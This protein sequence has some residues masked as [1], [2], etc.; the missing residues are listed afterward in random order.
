MDGISRICLGGLQS[1]FWDLRN[2]FRVSTP[3]FQ[4]LFQGYSQQSFGRNFYEK[5]RQIQ[6]AC[7]RSATHCRVTAVDI[8]TLEK[9]CLEEEVEG[10]QSL[11]R[12]SSSSGSAWPETIFTEGT[13]SVHKGRIAGGSAG[14]VEDICSIAEFQGIFFCSTVRKAFD[15]PQH[16][17]E[18]LISEKGRS[19]VQFKRICSS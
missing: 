3:C 8:G 5:T 4:G 7:Y 12:M 11:R 6:Y 15:S 19:L 2:A 1:V 10:L 9:M 16:P 18:V 14:R 13:R 17:Q